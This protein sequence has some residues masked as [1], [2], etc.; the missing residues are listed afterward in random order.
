VSIYTFIRE[1][2]FYHYFQPIYHL[3]NWTKLG[4]EV[5]L[6]SSI[7]SNPEDTFLEAKKEGQ[8][9]ELDTQSIQ[10][11]IQ[12]YHKAGLRNKDG[13]LFLNIFPSTILNKKFQSFL[14]KI[15]ADNYLVSQQIV[16]EISESEIIDDFENFKI[17]ILELKKQGILIA[18][19]DI[20]KGY[21]SF[22]NIV[23]LEPDFLKLD[24][25]FAKDLHLSKH[26]QTL[27]SFFLSYCE[28]FNSHLILE[29]VEN[30][31][32]IAIAKEVGISLAQGYGIGKPALL[33][34]SVLQ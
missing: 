14:N 5:L 11:A 19:D 7:Y 13:V 30:E 22:K 27:I 31:E 25:Y 18:I 29:G 6:R 10:K 2:Q 9:Y 26:K 4:Y 20:G 24:R 21:A 12:T 34:E 3:S 32:E 15:I 16:F 23:E 17:R 33:Q 8:L 1:E 28:Q